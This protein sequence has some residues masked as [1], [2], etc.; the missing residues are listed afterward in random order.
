MSSRQDY[1]R[2]Q[3]FPQSAYHIMKELPHTKSCFVCG[4]FNPVGLKLR[5]ETDGRTVQTRFVPM[6]EHIG[7]R[8]T[9]HGGLMATLLDEAMV[10]ACALQTKRFAFCAEL[11]TRFIHPGRPNQALVATAELVANR[12]NRLFEAR[13][14]LRDEAGTVLATATGK[15]LPIKD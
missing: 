12:R 11:T 13:A 14:E 15:Y 10:W 8:H 9:M 4:E 2:I 7:F 5:F 6:P 3:S 1:D